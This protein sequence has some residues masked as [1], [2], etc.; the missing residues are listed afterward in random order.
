MRQAYDYWQDQPGNYPSENPRSLLRDATGTLLRL[1]PFKGRSHSFH[2][3]Q[4]ESGLPRKTLTASNRPTETRSIFATSFHQFTLVSFRHTSRTAKSRECQ[5][6]TS[7]KNVSSESQP[8]FLA[9]G[10]HVQQPSVLSLSRPRQL[11]YMFSHFMPPTEQVWSTL[12]L[13]PRNAIISYPRT[14]YRA[15]LTRPDRMQLNCSFGLSRCLP[16][17]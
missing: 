5:K 15:G 11:G 14:H 4:R 8:L 7:R 6:D 10:H 12:L 17:H 9:K 3:L 16:S 13:F 2:N 1:P